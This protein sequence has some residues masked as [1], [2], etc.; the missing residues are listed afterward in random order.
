MR[1]QRYLN[2][3]VTV[4]NSAYITIYFHFAVADLS[5]FIKFCY[6]IFSIFSFTFSG[7]I[8][9]ATT[10]HGQIE[11]VWHVMMGIGAPVETNASAASAVAFPSLATPFVNSV[12]APAAP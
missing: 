2:V 12:M 7:V 6:D 10:T 4:L 1:N 5:I 9:E 8:Q 11:M 3:I